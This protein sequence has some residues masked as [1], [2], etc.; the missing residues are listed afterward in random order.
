MVGGRPP[1]PLHSRSP[2]VAHRE[3]ALGEV[4]LLRCPV[5]T[6]PHNYVLFAAGQEVPPHHHGTVE[7]FFGFH[8]RNVVVL[9]DDDDDDFSLLF[10]LRGHVEPTGIPVGFRVRS[11]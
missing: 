10:A 3:Q 5:S 9:D 4:P 1:V 11:S 6:G 8:L 2:L 7:G